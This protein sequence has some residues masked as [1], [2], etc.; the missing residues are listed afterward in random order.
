MVESVKKQS[1]QNCIL[2]FFKPY[3]KYWELFVLFLPVL[4][5]LIV[6]CYKPMGG[7]VIDFQDFKILEGI[8]GS[9]WVGLKNFEKITRTPSFLRV[10]S[11][12]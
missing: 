6:F 8:E 7:V 9:A 3:I 5:Y 12:S 1:K 11:N 4:I 2:N 10:L